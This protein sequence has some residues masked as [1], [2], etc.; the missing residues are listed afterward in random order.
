MNKYKL[1]GLCLLMFLPAMIWA[2]PV[3]FSSVVTT[4]ADQ[5]L[6]FPAADNRVVRLV[7]RQGPVTGEGIL[8]PSQML[9]WGIHDIGPELGSGSGFLVF[10]QSDQDKAY[11]S[12]NWQAIRLADKSRERFVLK[13]SWRVVSGSG[14]FQGLQG[15]GTLS[16]S[17]LSA[18][19]RQWQFDG[20]LMLVGSA[21]K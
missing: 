11:L 13:G 20:E 19:Q 8:A 7:Q 6:A 2:E 14:K 9:E 10:S 12:F 1:A 17:V 4:E 18:S 16:I 15:L 3:S 5:N 21:D